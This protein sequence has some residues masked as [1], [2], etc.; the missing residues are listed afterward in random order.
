MNQAALG[1]LLLSVI[2]VSTFLCCREETWIAGCRGSRVHAGAVDTRLLRRP[3][4]KFGTR[5]LQMPDIGVFTLVL[6][7]YRADVIDI[8]PFQ[9]IGMVSGEC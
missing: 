6:S 5:T 1:V 7:L 4:Y 2:G 3:L 9:M 8:T